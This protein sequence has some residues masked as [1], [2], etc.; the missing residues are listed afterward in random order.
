LVY[1][2]N[3]LPSIELK[4]HYPDVSD[5]PDFMRKLIA[6]EERLLGAADLVLTPSEVTRNYLIERGAP[7]E[8]IE[9]IANGVDVDFFPYQPVRKMPVP[10]QKL[11]VLYSG[12]LSSWQGVDVAIEAVRLYRRDAPARLTV[13]GPARNKRRRELL[14]LGERA[15]LG[16]DLTLLSPV[17]QPELA[18]LHHGADAVLAP[19]LPND[20]NKTQG[21]C[22]LKVLEAMASGTP[23]VASDLEV[24][25]LLARNEEEALLVRPGSA[26]AIKDALVRLVSERELGARLSRTARKRVEE[27]FTWSHAQ[28]SLVRCY[29]ELLG[30]NLSE[31]SSRA[32]RRDIVS[33]SCLSP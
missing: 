22:P 23:L 15:Q 25:S 33:R 8:R 7:A 12:T 1:E 13:V 26:K 19:L 6:Q 27:Q 18:A 3:G 28:S 9:V 20:R 11:E 32:S 21:C 5:D 31:D 29:S 16:D 24:V 4:Y 14:A 2:V 10:P 30:G 17:S